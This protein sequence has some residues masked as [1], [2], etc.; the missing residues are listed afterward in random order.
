MT[1]EFILFKSNGKFTNF[2]HT[3][4]YNYIHSAL[5]ALTF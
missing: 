4:K 1:T 2:R 3:A 5:D